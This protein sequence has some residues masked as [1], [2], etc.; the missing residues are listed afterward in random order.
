MKYMTKTSWK[1]LC[2]VGLGTIMVL[3][4]T[5]VA[6]GTTSYRAAPQGAE[7]TTEMQ[8]YGPDTLHIIFG[9]RSQAAE[10][11]AVLHPASAPDPAPE[12]FF[13]SV[14]RPAD[15]TSDFEKPVSAPEP[16]E[17][18]APSPG[19]GAVPEPGTFALLALGIVG[20]VIRYRQKIHRQKM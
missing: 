2:A 6:Q 19:S 9:E 10:A 1:G 14:R 13:N 4:I 15:G 12:E 7:T 8:K 16:G 20:V 17:L 18:S 3:G 11:E 5:H